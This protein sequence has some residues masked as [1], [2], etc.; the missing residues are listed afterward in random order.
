MQATGRK[1]GQSRLYFMK[2]TIIAQICL[3][4]EHKDLVIDHT[5]KED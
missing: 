5:I 1:R 2:C 4:F 3:S